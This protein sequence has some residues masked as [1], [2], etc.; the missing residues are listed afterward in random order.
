M[1]A[2]VRI[3][4]ASIALLLPAPAEV[5]VSVFAFC[6]IPHQRRGANAPEG[7]ATCPAVSRFCSTT[8]RISRRISRGSRSRTRRLRAP[9]ATRPDRTAT[10]ALLDRAVPLFGRLLRAHLPALERHVGDL[11]IGPLSYLPNGLLTC[12]GQWM[13]LE[14][15]PPCRIGLRQQTRKWPR[16]IKR[17]HVYK[18][19]ARRPHMKA[20]GS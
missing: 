14:A 13:P 6:I 3:S 20:E 12:F 4:S 8:S 11:G 18:N 2:R 5:S 7:R 16:A 9:T 19:T 15:L 1:P 10:T 17:H